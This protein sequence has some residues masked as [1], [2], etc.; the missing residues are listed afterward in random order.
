VKNGFLHYFGRDC[1]WWLTLV[2]QLSIL[3]LAYIAVKVGKTH[4]HLPRVLKLLIPQGAKGGI[5]DHEVDIEH[6]QE[7]E[8]DVAVREKLASLAKYGMD[9]SF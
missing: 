8:Q 2:L 1:I 6:W 7:L 4:L 5:E 9:R 3:V